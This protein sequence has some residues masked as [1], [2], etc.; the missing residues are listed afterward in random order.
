L[1]SSS[2]HASN[3]RRRQRPIART[4]FIGRD[5]ELRRLTQLVPDERLVTLLGVGGVGKTRLILEAIP[6]VRER[7]AGGVE[8][9]E[10]AGLT[11]PDF[12]LVAI[13]AA[14]GI[15]ASSTGDL[16]D[17]FQERFQ[18]PTLVVLDNFERI[19]TA[20]ASLSQLLDVCPLLHIVV[21]SRAALRLTGE[22][23]F[24]VGPLVIPPE[25]WERADLDPTLSIDSVALFIDRARARGL[26]V[27]LA[28]DDLAA[29]VE[30]C[31]RLGGWP[32]AIELAAAR[33]KLLGLPELAKRLAD[34]LSTLTEGAVDAAPRHRTIADT[35]A[36][37]VDLLAPDDRRAFA[38][39]STFAGGFTVD[40]AATLL[41]QHALS[42]GLDVIGRLVDHSLLE[43]NLTGPDAR[44]SM[45][46]PVREFASS[47][48]DTGTRQSL[49]R[50]HLDYFLR[51]AERESGLERAGDQE[52]WLRGMTAERDNIRRALSFARDSADPL[53]LLRLA[54]AL[55]RR[56]WIASGDLGLSES[57]SW[58]EAALELG[59]D[60]SP[61]LRGRTLMRLAWAIDTS[62]DD[63]ATV[64]RQALSQFEEARD[65]DGQIDALSGLGTVAAH[66]GDWDGAESYLN[67]GLELAATLGSRSDL[68]AEL[69]IALGQAK[70][71]RGDRATA[72]SLF[73]NAIA[74]ARTAGD[75]WALGY[76]LA[77]LGQLALSEGQ[78]I[79]AQ[80]PLLQS[81]RMA[82]DVGDLEE[83][84]AATLFL[85]ASKVAVGDLVGARELIVEAAGADSRTSSNVLMLDALSLWL[86]AAGK[87]DAAAVLD[88][89][90]DRVAAGRITR[91][92]SWIPIRR[93]VEEGLPRWTR[94]SSTPASAADPGWSANAAIAFGL[95][96]LSG[97]TANAPLTHALSAREREV[98]AYVVNGHSDAEI[99][100]ELFISKKTVSVHVSRI[101]DKLGAESRVGIALAALRLGLV[102]R[103]DPSAGAK[104]SEA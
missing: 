60:A 101:K 93:A 99:A 29:V 89:V 103:L 14:V 46:E 43:V 13:A 28:D 18:E 65:A 34:P 48:L 24:V 9:V 77:Q 49:F 47:L 94:P 61:A 4:R 44:F 21:T 98:L 80:E 27:P 16:V 58:L 82:R 8:V 57:R 30:I 84:V 83:Y 1:G 22:R 88:A 85:S 54:A 66:T 15:R 71:G 51:L 78:T 74:G 41:E 73:E 11:D 23:E 64:A 92:M 45:L 6:R 91:R 17:A 97:A 90:A 7:F 79:A 25:R 5:E 19:L 35:V 68:R 20:G 50:A 72:R 86:A 76:G 62:P 95:D 96:Q 32:L 100:R 63:V 81:R 10:L 40:A 12:L 52:T 37:S 2:N 102:D 104:R 75:H 39:M 38:A 31:R 53:R 56:F 59:A 33:V 70:A 55:E 42:S 36:W 3:E 69:L 87:V 26:E 67:R